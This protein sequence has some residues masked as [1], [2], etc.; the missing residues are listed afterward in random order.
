MPATGSTLAPGETVKCTA[1]YTPTQAD[2]DAGS[3][4]NTGTVTGPGRPASVTAT[5][6][7]VVPRPRR[8]T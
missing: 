2:L 4:A 6:T 5:D 7:A 8:R 1:S 3:V